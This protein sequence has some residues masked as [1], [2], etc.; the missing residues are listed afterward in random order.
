MSKILDIQTYNKKDKSPKINFIY[1]ITYQMLILILPLITT[2]YLSRVVGAS[3]VGIYS[4][5]YS[6]VYYFMLL[7]LLGVNN[8]GNRSIAKVRDNKEKLSK[9]FWSIYFLQLFMGILMLIVYFI[10]VFISNSQYKNIAIIQSLYIISAILDI[11]WFYF[12]LEEFKVTITRN[13]IVKIGSI[14][15]I[16]A[17]VKSFDDLWKYVLI[18][19]GTTVLSQLILWLLLKKKINF[20]KISFKDIFIHIKPNLVLFI[21]VIAISLYKIMDKIML[22]RMSNVTEVGFYENAEKIASIPMTIV[23]ALGTVMLPRMS[24]IVAKGEVD[25]IKTYISKSISFVQFLSYAMC[26]GLIAIGY[27]FAPI[28]FGEEFQK[29]GT[30]IMLLATTIPF[31]AFANV[32]RT[33]Y[34]IPNEQDK[35]YI[36]S[37][38]LGALINFIMN[39]IFIP[40]FSSIGA[41]FGTIA[42]E[43]MV[44]FYQSFAV[45]KTLDIKSYLKE[46][47]AF[48]IKA[49][50]MCIIIYP[51]NFFQMN[52]VVR[53]LLQV[54]IGVIIYVILNYKYV[55]SIINKKIIKINNRK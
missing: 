43:F 2:P 22:G 6:I 4:Y 49:I 3:G 50:I 12:G 16:F 32:I 28:F 15:L 53:I 39:I 14:V 10:Y 24:N 11:N 46:G 29:S 19:S 9:T 21:P 42:A 35:V 27:N 45:R 20:I 37:V 1:N 34:L 36:V 13:S 7:C 48:L 17:L 33:Q 54:T 5:T 55:F 41:C 52:S 25:K 31:L 18:M 47:F 26:F 8:Y 44:M 51:F 30:L 38:F 23:S 40:Y